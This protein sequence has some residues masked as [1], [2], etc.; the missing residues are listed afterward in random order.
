MSRR[1]YSDRD[2]EEAMAALASNGN[3]VFKTA[4]ELGIPPRTI[5]NWAE[6]KSHPELANVGNGKKEELA[7]ILED[8]AYKAVDVADKNVGKLNAKDAITAAAIAIDKMRLLR[9]QSTANISVRPDLSQ[10][11]DDEL[12]ILDQVASQLASRA[13]GNRVGAL[14]SVG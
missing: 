14:S 4:K 7:G 10:L 3:N 6:G 5:A 8:F 2:R 13:I 1:R 12:N 11:T 9:D